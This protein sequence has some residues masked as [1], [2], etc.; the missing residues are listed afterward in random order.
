MK[1]SRCA[2]PPDALVVVVPELEALLRE[3][4]SAP[5]RIERLLATGFR[6]ALDDSRAHGELVTGEPIAPAALTR[7]LDCPDEARGCWL[8]ADPVDLT[9]DL[10]SVW[11]HAGARMPSET[12]AA[13][14]L[15]EMFDEEGLALDFPVPERGYIRLERE[16][17]CRFSPPWRLAGE[18]MDLVFPK[19]A[20][21][22]YWRRLLNETQV[23]LHQH[24]RQAENASVSLP[25]SL[26]FWGAGSLPDRH[27]TAVRVA[28]IFADD[29]VFVALADWLGLECRA[30]SREV[31]PGAGALIEWVAEHGLSAEENL[32]RLDAFLKR[33][34][35]RLRLDRNMKTLELA[36]LEH[37]WR[38][39]TLDAWRVWR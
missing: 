23:V 13:S 29:V 39:S 35:R 18:S 11:L 8:R 20:E 6:R 14:E 32:D 31:D 30:A 19:G 37:A 3:A 25:G 10:T 22:G 38:F 2:T 17:D 36:S 26:W 33:A 1:S 21:A 4:G 7:N 15:T 34:W 16:P 12:A 5:R 27:R 24:R 9:P 28:R